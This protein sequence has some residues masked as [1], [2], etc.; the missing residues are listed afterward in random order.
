MAQKIDYSPCVKCRAR[1]KSGLYC[2]SCSK[3][4]TNMETENWEKQEG[5]LTPVWEYAKAGDE[6]IGTLLEI[7]KGKF[8]LDNYILEDKN[9]SKWMIWGKAI[10]QSRML[11][12][13]IG[14]TVKIVY[15]GEVKTAKGMMAAN[16][17]VFKAKGKV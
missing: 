10:L 12:V 17:E 4:N 6:L 3:E 15:R 14:D 1:I 5:E 13:A 9:K 8:A 11:N 7:R 16:F 2:A